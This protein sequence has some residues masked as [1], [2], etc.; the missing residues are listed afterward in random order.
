VGAEKRS[1]IHM[2]IGIYGGSRV[3]NIYTNVMNDGAFFYCRN[4]GI[5]SIKRGS[6]TVFE[7]ITQ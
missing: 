2:S 6:I 1:I 7:I 5:F 4:S 3:G